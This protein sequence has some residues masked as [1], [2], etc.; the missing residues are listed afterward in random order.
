M[1]YWDCWRVDC[2]DY[3]GVAGDAVD[4]NFATLAILNGTSYPRCEY[5]PHFSAQR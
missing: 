4:L 3:P 1:R 5:A 2:R